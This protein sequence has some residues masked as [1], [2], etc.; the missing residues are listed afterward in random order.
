MEQKMFKKVLAVAGA[1]AAL[2]MIAGPALADD[3]V[4]LS[5]PAPECNMSCTAPVISGNWVWLPSIGVPEAAWGFGTPGSIISEQADLP[6]SA[7]NY[8]NDRGGVSWLLENSAICADTVP[9][10][11]TEHGIQTGCGE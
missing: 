5:R 8:I 4:N 6:G 1:T 3:C 10:R 11:Q 9:S 7:G 2:M